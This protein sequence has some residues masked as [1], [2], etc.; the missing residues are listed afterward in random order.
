MKAGR[1]VVLTVVFVLLGTWAYGDECNTYRYVNNNDGTITDC[2][3]G[4]IWLKNT[5]C[6]ETLG[7]IPKSNGY[8]NWHDAMLWSA[9]L[10]SGHCGLTDGSRAGFWRLPTVTEWMAMVRA[11]REKLYSGISGKAALN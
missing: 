3:T 1:V 11:G 10:R 5:N 4:L 9:A 8:I 7:G 2:R 6:T